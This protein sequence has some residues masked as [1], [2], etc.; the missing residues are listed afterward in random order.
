MLKSKFPEESKRCLSPENITALRNFKPP[1]IEDIEEHIFEGVIL[2]QKNQICHG[3]DHLR[4]EH[5]KKLIGW[6][7]EC[8]GSLETEFRSLYKYI[9]LR[10]MNGDIPKEVRPM[11][12]DTEAFAAPKSATDIRPLGK[13][14]LDRKIAAALLLKINR[15]EILHAFAGVQYGCDPKGTEKIIHST[16]LGMQA[17]P[18]YD[19]FAPDATN[20]FNLCNR[21]IG[22]HELMQRAPSMYAFTNFLYGSDSKTWFHGME[23]GIQGIDCREGSQQGCNLGNLL[24]GMSFQPFVEDISKIV[25]HEEDKA[26]F[27]NFFVDD[28]NILSSPAL[29]W[30]ALGYMIENGP[31]YCYHM[32]LSK[33]HN[34]IT[35]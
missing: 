6:G 18:E 13:I 30:P 15:K 1:L 17:H 29:M 14:N 11:Y 3:F 23:D 28:G 4:N 35:S 33:S 20:A 9:I 24:C 26:A 12:T 34:F 2:G 22:L 19:L 25:K 7:H 27:A 8:G 21:G 16:R 32:N 10:L 5:L 31:I